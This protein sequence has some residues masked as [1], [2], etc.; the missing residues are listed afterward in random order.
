MKYQFTHAAGHAAAVVIQNA[1]FPGPKKKLSSL[2]M[3]WATYTDPEIAHVGMYAK[4]AA[5]AGIEIDTYIEKL[6]KNDRALADGDTDGFVKVHVRKGTDKIV[7]ATIVG[8]HASEMLTIITTLMTLDQGLGKLASVIFPY[9]TQAEAIHRIAGQ[10]RRTQLKPTMSK[11]L[12]WWFK[13]GR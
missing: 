13:R 8:S 3:P 9:P 10:Y 5:D 6:A 11:I 12:N 7:G 4:D 2:V 1:L